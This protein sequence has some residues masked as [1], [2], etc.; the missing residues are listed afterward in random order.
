VLRVA[1]REA[2]STH[3]PVASLRGVRLAG[4]AGE[5]SLELGRGEWLALLGPA[6]AG[7]SAVIGLLAGLLRPAAGEVLLDG[8][9]ADGLPPHRR[10]VG[11]V[12]AQ[13]GPLPGR[14]V[15]DT[16]R[17]AANRAAG[18]EEAVTSAL[19]AFGLAA[20]AGAR[21]EQLD[22]AGRVRTAFARACAAGPRIWLLDEPFAGLEAE[23]WAALLAAFK[24][25][26][27]GV[28]CVLATRSPEQALA[29]GGRVAL[30]DAGVVLQE[31]PV[32]TVYD[33]P[34]SVRAARL[35]GEAN[36]LPGRVERVEDGLAEVRLDCGVVVEA[37]AA[38][39]VAGQAGVV[40]VRPERIAVAAGPAD[41]MGER[42]LPARVAG[43]AW[44]GD[45][46]RLE[47]LLGGAGGPAA[48]LAVRRPAGVP[49]AATAPGGTVAVAWQPWHARVLPPMAQGPSR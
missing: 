36:C 15:G 47:L 30:L 39:A 35:L 4:A 27:A 33:A 25:V 24:A 46:V 41:E 40:M 22:A 1:S 49:L 10:G 31:G 8:V 17:F 45:H 26:A 16:L 42:A 23:G 43:L 6:R 3:P 11:L 34:A 2:A 37:D 32:Q 5:L 19:A 38:G 21:A 18:A 44:R 29:L 14:T 7:K 13:D 28:P 9:P 20:S 48:P 12:L